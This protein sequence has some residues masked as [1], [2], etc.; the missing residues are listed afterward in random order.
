MGSLGGGGK[1]IPFKYI[2]LKDFQY[3]RLE[4][5]ISFSKNNV[6]N[7]EYRSLSVTNKSIKRIKKVWYF[8]KTTVWKPS[9]S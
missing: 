8:P 6:F 2:S 9:Y 4:K 3:E 7:L 1:S 5:V